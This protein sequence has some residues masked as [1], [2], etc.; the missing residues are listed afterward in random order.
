[1]IQYNDREI[2]SPATYRKRKHFQKVD[3]KYELINVPTYYSATGTGIAK[4]QKKDSIKKKD[5]AIFVVL[6]LLA[7]AGILHLIEKSKTTINN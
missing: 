2:Y 6:G 4:E 1:M 5:L 3:A 7:T